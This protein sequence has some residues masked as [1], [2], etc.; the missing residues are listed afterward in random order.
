MNVVHISHTDGGAGAGRAAYRIHRSLLRL[1]VGSSLLVAKKRTSDPSVTATSSCAFSLGRAKIFEYLEAKLARSESA[2]EAGLMSFARLGHFVPHRHPLVR[3][4]DVVCLYWINGAYVRPERLSQLQQPIVWRLSD[5]WPF[6]GGCHYPSGCER[7]ASCCGRCP[8]LARPS[9]NDSSRRLWRRKARAWRHLDLTVT[10]PSRWIA[11]LAQ[12]SALFGNRRVEVIPT[13][14]DLMAFRPIDRASARA[15][16][17]IA[18]DRLTIVYGSL[19][20]NDPRKGYSLLEQALSQLAT[21]KLAPRLLAVVFGS[22][23]QSSRPLPVPTLF[24]GQLG[25]DASLAMAYSVADLVAVPSLEDNLPNI[26]LEAISCG[27]PVVGFN[28]CGMPDIVRHGWNGALAPSI[29]AM[30]FAKEMEHLLSDPRQRTFMA[31]NA[32]KHAENNFSID[33]QARAYA[34]LYTE[35]VQKSALAPNRRSSIRAS[36]PCDAKSC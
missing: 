15:R 17:G 13:G 36:D 19:D 22:K 21:T 5:V 9:E 10:A 24:L 20:S 3:A 28:V 29:D 26:A 18:A 23:N 6:T 35:L 30:A 12:T 27:A 11:S 7:H 33:A 2:P 14:I 32:R 8:Q 25:D 31:E 1:G 34:A 4:A 16:L